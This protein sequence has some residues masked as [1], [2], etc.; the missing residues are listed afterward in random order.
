[1]NC[2]KI[3]AREKA[4]FRKLPAKILHEYF[5][6]H[7]CTRVSKGL[8][9]FENTYNKNEAFI[10][11]GFTCKTFRKVKTVHCSRLKIRVKNPNQTR[12]KV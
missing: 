11:R 9:N 5:E 1:M 10:V 7:V 4:C 2:R 6:S 12:T 8:K 3:Y